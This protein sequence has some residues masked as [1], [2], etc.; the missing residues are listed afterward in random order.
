MILL[1]I[2]INNISFETRLAI[3]Y[4]NDYDFIVVGAGSAG[5]VVASRLSENNNWT[6]LLL[7]AGENPPFVADVMCSF[8]LFFLN[9]SM[10]LFKFGFVFVICIFRRFRHCL[11][12]SKIRN[13][14][15][16]IRQTRQWLVSERLTDVLGLEVKF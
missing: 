10:K 14:T 3:G 6:I 9:F 5:S 16:N 2:I 4:L 8:S 12:H 11:L 1:L 15:G 7:E 13:S